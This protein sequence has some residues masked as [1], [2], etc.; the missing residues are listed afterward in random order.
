MNEPNPGLVDLSVDTPTATVTLNR[1]RRH[2][3]LV[4]AMLRE[5]IASLERVGT[6]PNVSVVIL[7]A[8][9][10]SFSTGGD[11]AAFYDHRDDLATYAQEVVG[12]LNESML[13]LMRLP[14]PV[15]AA[16]H[17]V[18]TGGAMGLVL[19][20]DVVV[21]SPSATFTPWY[22]VVGFAPDGG[23]SAILPERIGRARAADVLLNNRTIT[24]DQAVGWG[25]AGEVVASIDFEQRV[26]AVAVGLASG[27]VAA[28]KRSLNAD[29]AETAR[30]LEL[31]RRAFVE[32]VVTEESLAGMAAFL[33]RG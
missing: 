9:G 27:K 10:P 23:W 31:E 24:A 28:V 1:S 25:I 6:D 15:I 2:N 17:G 21:V 4:P 8:N 30:R 11:V 20:S 7:A 19:A 32:Q 5:L 3:S 13:G 22:S 33:A 14:Q 26:E 12:L 29:I 18:V 16:V